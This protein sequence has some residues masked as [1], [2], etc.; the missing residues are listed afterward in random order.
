MTLRSRMS[1]IMGVI[2]PEQLE[3]SCPS[4]RKFFRVVLSPEHKFVIS[5]L[6]DLK[7]GICICCDKM[8]CSMKEP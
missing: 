1:L 8:E 3:F 2:K 6:I 7:L 5:S 4:I